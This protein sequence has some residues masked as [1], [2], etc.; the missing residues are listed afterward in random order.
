[1]R[2]L[3]RLW[4]RTTPAPRFTSKKLHLAAREDLRQLLLA[5]VGDQLRC[6]IDGNDLL[7]EQIG[8]QVLDRRDAAGHRRDRLAA[9]LEPRDV[10]AQLRGVGVDDLRVRV[11]FQISGKL[12]DVAEIGTEGI[13]G[14]I[15]L[16][17]Q[18]M[19]K[20]LDDLRI[21]QPGPSISQK[22]Q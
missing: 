14:S 12:A 17:L 13:G 3:L 22:I 5:L 19:L 1:M 20:Q 6:G 15:L 8:I 11:G 7:D 2:S 16:I 4:Q 9:L 18:I 21:R 10:F